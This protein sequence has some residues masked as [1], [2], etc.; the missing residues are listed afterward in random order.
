MYLQ[1]LKEK[2]ASK[3]GVL[4]TDFVYPPQSDL[5]DLSLP[6]FSLSKK[7]NSSPVEIANS[8]LGAVQSDEEL[9]K[10]F[11]KTEVKGPY[12][13]F[14]LAKDYLAKES[15]ADIKKA[16]PEFGKNNVGKNKKIM[17][18]YSNV[19]THKEYHVGHLRNLFFG[20]S[21]V[22]LFNYNN[23]EAISASYINDFGIHVAK[24]IWGWQHGEAKEKLQAELKVGAPKGYLLGSCYS[25]ASQEILKDDNKKVAVTE[26]MK[27]IESRQGDQ[28]EL[29][30]ETRAWSIDYFDNIYREL[31][32][33]FQ[34][35]FY[36]SEFIEVG[37]KIVTEFLA[38]G[39]FKKSEG[40]IIADLE[41]FNLGVLP[42]IRSDETALYPVADLAL[43]RAKFKDYQLDESVYIVDVRQ[44]LY[45]KQ[46][47]KIFELS[48]ENLKI[49]HLGYDFVT[50]K[51]GMMS[52]RS[53]NVITYRELIEEAVNRSVFEIKS[54]HDDW[55]DDKINQIAKSLA[56]AALKFEM[57][58]VSS[59]KVIV[60]DL[61][62]AL[63]FDGY[64]AAYLQYSGAR[65]ASILRKAEDMSQVIKGALLVEDREKNI[66]LN[67]QK[68]PEITLQAAFKKDPSLIARYLF[69]LAQLFNDYY[70]SVPIL[71]AEKDL[72]LARLALLEAVQQV[73]KNGFNILGIEYLEEM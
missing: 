58:K 43:A 65:L 46:L 52:S 33:D 67:L 14:F 60:F 13:N 7:L 31:G 30:Q 21:L 37:L 70:H 11:E 16:G 3:C 32:I 62:E 9:A 48:G 4:T 66:I 69:E 72:S 10:F 51:S 41:E 49:S 20:D 1:D 54:R 44:G 6:T 73:L 50:L 2:L 63:R 56:R 45:F 42:I 28:Y 36:E 53:G 12:L 40:A 38:K 29:W 18:E 34:Y 47:E 68:F 27:A 15:L 64:T 23:Y 71:K 35:I 55:E 19:N 61:N 25:L 57:L 22:R 17:F 24:A 39:I 26:I 59:D 5:G 8:L